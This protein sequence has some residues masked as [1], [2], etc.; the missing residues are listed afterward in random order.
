MRELLKEGNVLY[1]AII[2]IMLTFVANSYAMM[3]GSMMTNAGMTN[4]GGFGMMNGM[5][6]T[7][8]LGDDGTAYLVIH[9]PASNAGAVPNSNSFESK[10]F[11]AKTTGETVS[12]T[13]KGITSKPVVVGAVLVAT[14]S[15]PDLNNYMMVYNY[16]T[17]T[18]ASQAV[19]YVLSLPFSASSVPLAIALDGSYASI[20]VIANNKVYVTTTDFGNAMMQ[21]NNT[22]AGMYG[23]YNFSSTGSA[24]SYLYILNLDGT[25]ASKIIIQ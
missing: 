25:I 2:L 1:T 3:D 22:F 14:A 16:V 4:T 19:L 17:L 9:N 7:P 21:G 10:L 12:L 15:L 18:T 20:P 11:A 13:L 5:A 24:K 8:V 6:G 23:A